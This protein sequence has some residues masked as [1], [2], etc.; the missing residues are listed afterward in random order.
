MIRKTL[1]LALALVA[2]LAAPAAA[3]YGSGSGSASND[4]ETITVVGEGFAPNTTVDYS[5]EYGGEVVETGETTSD[6]E[7]DVQ[8]TVDVRGDGT[9]NITMTDGNVTVV[10]STTV[11]AGAAPAPAPAPA[12]PAG[13]GALPRT[14]DDTTSTLAQV[15][16]AAVAMGAVAVYGAKRRKAKAFA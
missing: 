5:V 13:S 6:A 1:I 2:L 16:F 10:A 15:G 9:Y 12:A 4:G 7:G 3:Q 14:G 11:G 8:F